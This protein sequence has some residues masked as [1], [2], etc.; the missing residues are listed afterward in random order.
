MSDFSRGIPLEK[1]KAYNDF[2]KLISEHNE[3]IG[4]YENFGFRDFVFSVTCKGVHRDEIYNEKSN[5]DEM[6]VRPIEVTP[7]EIYSAMV[8]RLTDKGKYQMSLEDA[9]KIAEQTKNTEW[10]AFVFFDKSTHH[11]VIV[12]PKTHYMTPLKPDDY[13]YASV[14]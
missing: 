5:W 12:L 4:L 8:N 11:G 6:C 10:T 9:K 3:S 14:C 2:K 7:K 13:Y 1:T